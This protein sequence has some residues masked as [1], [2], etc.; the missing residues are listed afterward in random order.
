[1]DKI[2]KATKTSN[3]KKKKKAGKGFESKYKHAFLIALG[4]GQR[5]VGKVF[6]PKELMA[7]NIFRTGVEVEGEESK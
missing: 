2:A 5:A 7:S 4:D 6:L 3:G 1:L